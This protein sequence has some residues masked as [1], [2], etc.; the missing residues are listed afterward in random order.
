MRGWTRSIGTVRPLPPHF[1]LD[2][3]YFM[4]LF[5]VKSECSVEYQDVQEESTVGGYDALSHHAQG[6]LQFT[7]PEP[8]MAG[9]WPGHGGTMM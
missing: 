4:R 7:K 5:A 9:S 8:D 1:P 3:A 6:G 2:F